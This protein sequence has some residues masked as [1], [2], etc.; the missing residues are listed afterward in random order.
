[1][2]IKD[3]PGKENPMV[4]FLSRIPK[5]DDLATVEDQFPDEHLFVV[6][7]KTPWYVDVTN[8]LVVGKL[9]KHLTPSK[10]KQIVQCNT[11]FSW[12]E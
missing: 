11:Q 7:M 2:I 3:R 10:R 1:M 4:D 6:T 5:I 12:I 8:Y 9:P